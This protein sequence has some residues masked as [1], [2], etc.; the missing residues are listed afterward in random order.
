MIFEKL[1][2]GISLSAPIGPVS[3]EM[4]RR[5]LQNGFLSAFIIRL[6]GA[7]GNTLCLI[8]AYFGLGLINSSPIFMNVLGIIGSLVLIYMGAKAFMDKRKHNLK[9]EMGQN[10]YSIINGLMTGFVLSIA[11]PIGIVFWLSIFA[12]SINAEASQVSFIGLTENFLIIVG[13]LIWGACLSGFLELGKRYFTV[14]V[15][16][17]ITLCA[18]V[19]LIGFGAKYG[20]YAIN[21]IAQ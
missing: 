16:H 18:G 14:K 8:G 7:I 20:Y 12:A 19:L 2:L 5:G 10:K 11:N 13:V 6:G 9:G 3:L 1:L 15:I 21:A 17:A 4:I